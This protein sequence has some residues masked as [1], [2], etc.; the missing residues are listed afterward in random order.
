MKLQNALVSLATLISTVSA[1]IPIE[2]KGNRFVRPA[3]NSSD[4][5][6]VFQIVGIDYQPGGSSGFD[7]SSGSDLLSDDNYDNCLRD[8]FL[9]QQLGINTI[10]VY[11][12]VFQKAGK[13][14]K[15]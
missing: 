2:V 5:G 3:S 14:S 7:L 12:L 11:R 8:A 1:L 4:Q 13:V 6:E 9:F 10:R 15:E